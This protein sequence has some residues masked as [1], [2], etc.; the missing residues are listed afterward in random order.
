MRAVASFT[1]DSFD[2]TPPHFREESLGHV[3]ARLEKTFRGEIAGHGSVEMLAARADAGSGYVALERITAV[4]NGRSGG[5][6]L[7]HVGTMD[8]P[9][10]WARWL[11]APG[12][13]TGD[14]RAIRGEG[15][16]AIN[17]AGDHTFTLDYQLD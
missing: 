15:Q 11:V 1:V 13:G 10:M 14:L 17:E 5:F 9:E 8:G 3:R 16:I 4:V 2:G 12:S 6:S 7:L